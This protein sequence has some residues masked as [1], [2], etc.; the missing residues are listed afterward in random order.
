MILYD[1]SNFHFNTIIRFRAI[2]SSPYRPP[3][4]PSLHRVQATPPP[5]PKKKKK[6]PGPDRV[7]TAKSFKSILKDLITLDKAFF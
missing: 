2:G 6:K 1:H 7:K 3:P 4:T 5:P